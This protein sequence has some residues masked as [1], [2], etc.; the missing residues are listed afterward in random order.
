MSKDRVKKRNKLNKNK[1]ATDSIRALVIVKTLSPEL[2]NKA[3]NHL[4][5]LFRSQATEP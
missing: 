4:R 2:Q 5:E 1:S 3:I